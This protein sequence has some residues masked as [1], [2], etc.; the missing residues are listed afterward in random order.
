MYGFPIDNANLTDIGF[1]VCNPL[2]N[3]PWYISLGKNALEVVIGLKPPLTLCV[4]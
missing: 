3:M 2:K 1:V 4:V